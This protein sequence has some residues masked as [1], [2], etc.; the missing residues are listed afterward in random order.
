MP[1]VRSPPEPSRTGPP[2]I[3]RR[4]RDHR[5]Q[6]A[7]QKRKIDR[8]DY[9]APVA[10]K[11]LR[12]NAWLDEDRAWFLAAFQHGDPFSEESRAA[13]MSSATQVGLRTAYARFLGFLTSEDPDRL[14]LS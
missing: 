9:M 14:R 12:L 6:L 5:L 10:T 2:F 13:H 8:N 7:R 1:P 11:H 3:R 4:L